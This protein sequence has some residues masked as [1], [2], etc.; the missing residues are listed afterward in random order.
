VCRELRRNAETRSVPII[1]LTA[2]G[3]ESDEVAGLREGA[4]D[5][6]KKPFSPRVLVA[7]VDAALRSLE[8]EDDD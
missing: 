3:D 4:N 7:R 1:M 6:I 2:L 8:E 5:Y